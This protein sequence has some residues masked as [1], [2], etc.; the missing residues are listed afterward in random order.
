MV[1]IEDIPIIGR[2]LSYGALAL[3]IGLQSG[4]FVLSLLDAVLSI[5]LGSP[6]TVV[7]LVLTLN[8][9]SDMVE[10]LPTALIQQVVTVALVALLVKRIL[11]YLGKAVDKA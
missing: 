1:D 11:D 3:D 2:V 5:A 8:R 10:W 4:E 7:S 9:L 6:E